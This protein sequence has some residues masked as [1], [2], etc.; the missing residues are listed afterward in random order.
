MEIAVLAGAGVV[1]PIEIVGKIKGAEV[2]GILMDYT[3]LCVI[4]ILYIDLTLEILNRTEIPV[5]VIRIAQAVSIRV[6]HFS[7]EAAVIGQMDAAPYAVRHRSDIVTAV[8]ERKAAGA[9]GHAPELVTVILEGQ[10]IPTKIDDA[11]NTAAI[12]EAVDRPRLIRHGITAAC[13]HQRVITAGVK[14]AVKAD[15]EIK[16]NGSRQMGDHGTA[17]KLQRIGEVGRPAAAKPVIFIRVDRFVVTCKFQIILA[18]QRKVTVIPC[19][20]AAEQIHRVAAAGQFIPNCDQIIPGIDRLKGVNGLTFLRH[21]KTEEA[22]IDRCPG[23]TGLHDDDIAAAAGNTGEAAAVIPVTAVPQNYILDGVFTFFGSI[24]QAEESVCAGQDR[25]FRQIV[26]L[27]IDLRLLLRFHVRNSFNRFFCRRLVLNRCHRHICLIRF[28]RLRIHRIRIGRCRV[29]I[30]FQ[31]F[32]I[33]RGS[34]GLIYRRCRLRIRCQAFLGSPILRCLIGRR[35]F[36]IHCFIVDVSGQICFRI[37]SIEI[38]RGNQSVCLCHVFRGRELIKAH[39]CSRI[40]QFDEAI[41]LK[42]KSVE[43]LNHFRLTLPAD[44]L[45]DDIQ[46]LIFI[47][48]RIAHLL[49]RINVIPLL[50]RDNIFLHRNAHQYTQSAAKE[51]LT[52]EF[53]VSIRIILRRIRHGNN[54]FI[55]IRGF[56]LH[57]IQFQRDRL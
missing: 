12:V 5:A 3:A 19:K 53:S 33:C 44:R 35:F 31:W 23:R 9:V 43:I 6:F 8:G 20:T 11:Q 13:L 15:W 2:Y 38:F 4:F 36:R 17:V 41:A 27:R 10:R 29:R 22:V 54:I 21:I 51:L 18:V 48:R 37:W 55:H 32:R 56:I 24:R 7:Q 14:A 34:K 49:R 46:P 1:P 26:D 52:L 42:A 30:I 39:R 16:R 40:V 45:I 25:T 28:H 57:L 47:D 50:K